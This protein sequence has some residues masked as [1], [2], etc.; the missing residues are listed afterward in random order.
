M[1][2]NLLAEDGHVRKFSH[3]LKLFVQFQDFLTND[4]PNR[5]RFYCGICQGK[6]ENGNKRKCLKFNA[7]FEILELPMGDRDKRET[8]IINNENDIWDYVADYQK[9]RIDIPEIQLISF[10]NGSDIC[11]IPLFDTATIEI[12]NYVNIMEGLSLPFSE[13]IKTP[14][15]IAD[16]MAVIKSE[17]ARCQAARMTNK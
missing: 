4:N 3:R 16:A 8:R 5:N 11:P 2:G 7:P 10:A 14:A 6:D 9:Y 13:W 1:H 12:V 17:Q 15:L